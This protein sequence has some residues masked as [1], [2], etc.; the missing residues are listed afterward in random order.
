[1]H[2]VQGVLEDESSSMKPAAHHHVE[3]VPAEPSGTN[4][5]AGHAMQG[6]VDK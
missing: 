1:M 2:C 4:E 3:Q 6:V 5:P